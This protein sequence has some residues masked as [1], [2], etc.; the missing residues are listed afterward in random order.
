M[1]GC[2]PMQGTSFG[3]ACLALLAAMAVGNAQMEQ[4]FT[5]TPTT[6]NLSEPRRLNLGAAICVNRPLNLAGMEMEATKAGE[7]LAE[8]IRAAGFASG[9]LGTVGHCDA[10][11]FTEITGLGRR[12]VELDFRI[13][14]ADEQ[15]PRL[16]SSARGK[17]AKLA[18]WHDAI[19]DAFADEARQIRN[20]QQKGMAVYAGAI[21][22]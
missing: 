13:V 6:P 19:L 11:V 16:C 5:T 17:S 22:Q 14:L 15:V 10:V 9:L 7:E 3:T 20:A 8:R 2:N 18:P 4:N 12:R 21:Q 1:E